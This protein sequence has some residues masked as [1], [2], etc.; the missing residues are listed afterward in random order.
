MVCR[1]GESLEMRD[2]VWGH[3]DYWV[4]D[5]EPVGLVRCLKPPSFLF[6]LTAAAPFSPVWWC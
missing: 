4:D 2:V 1:I 5:S 6:T 3:W